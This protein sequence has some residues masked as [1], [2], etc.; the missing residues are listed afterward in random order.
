MLCSL[1]KAEQWTLARHDDLARTGP[2]L[3]GHEIGNEHLGVVTQVI[4]AIGQVILV[5]PIG[6]SRGIGVVLEQEHLA[7][8][9]VLGQSLLRPLDQTLQDSLPRPVVSEKV[10]E[11]VTFSRGVF[12]VA[13]DV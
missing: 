9:A 1:R 11:I 3:S 8:N 7:S 6:I 10:E 2:N 13:P 4:G 12:R 5:A